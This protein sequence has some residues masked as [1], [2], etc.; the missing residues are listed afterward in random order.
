MNYT[1]MTKEKSLKQIE[2]EPLGLPKYNKQREKI[3]RLIFKLSFL[4]KKR[5]RLMLD[6]KTRLSEERLLLSFFA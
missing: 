2:L 5:K 6:V 3:M 4:E 1:K